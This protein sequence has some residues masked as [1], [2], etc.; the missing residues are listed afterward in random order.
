TDY[1]LVVRRQEIKL[2]SSSDFSSGHNFATTLSEADK[3]T[4]ALAFFVARIEAEPS[5]S[6]KIVIL[7]D[8]VSSMDRNRRHQTIRR[9]ATLATSCK[10]LIVLS[11]DAYFLR[12]LEE[13]LRKQVG[14]P[15]RILGI[16]RTYS[17]YSAF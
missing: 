4:L 14:T 6:S 9:I 13:Q 7:D 8:P 5:L 3:R 2:G 1:R 12:D 11:H 15:P 10:Q 17:G 16:S